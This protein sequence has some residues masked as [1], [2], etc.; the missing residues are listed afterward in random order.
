[1]CLV[2]KEAVRAQEFMPYISLHSTEKF[3]MLLFCLIHKDNK[4]QN[5]KLALQEQIL[6]IR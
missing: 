5:H 2:P 1:M 4:V 6:R 3:L